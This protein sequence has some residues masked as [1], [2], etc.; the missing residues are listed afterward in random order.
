[1]VGPPLPPGHARFSPPLAGFSAPIR[2][3]Y[4]RTE[5]LTEGSVTFAR[6]QIDDYD[7]TA[8]VARRGAR[9]MDGRQ[10]G[11]PARLAQALLTLADS[12]QPPLRFSAGEDPVALLELTLAAKA[13]ELAEWRTLSVALAHEQQNTARARDRSSPIGPCERAAG[14]QQNR[15]SERKPWTDATHPPTRE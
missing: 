5:Y 9:E 14:Q 3:P 1:M 12:A 8:G 10:G 7:P 4:F 2:P 15:D 11:E 13:R 6:R